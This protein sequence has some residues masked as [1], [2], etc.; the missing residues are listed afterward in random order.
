MRVFHFP[1]LMVF[2]KSDLLTGAEKIAQAQI[3]GLYENIG[4]ACLQASALT[5]ENIEGIIM[6]C[7]NTLS[8]FAG[9]SGTGKSAILSRVFPDHTFRISELSKN[10]QRG[11]HTTTGITLLKLSESSYIADT[12]GFSLM[13]LPQIPEEEVVSFFPDIGLKQGSCKFSNCIHENEPGC[14]IKE[15]VGKGEIPQS[16]Y[17]NYLKV[18]NYMNRKN[19]DYKGKMR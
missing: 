9:Q 13:E 8:I 11:V 16:R 10:I 12:P 19:R 6:Y 2:N 7:K 14:F 4:Y 3:A 5:G 15:M 18:Y 17:L 1:V